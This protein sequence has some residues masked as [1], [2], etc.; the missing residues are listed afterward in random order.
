M[1]ILGQY[2]CGLWDGGG[3]LWVAFFYA[4]GVAFGCWGMWGRADWWKGVLTLASL[5][6]VILA[7]GQIGLS[8]FLIGLTLI[9]PSAVLLIFFLGELLPGWLGFGG[10]PTIVHRPR[11]DAPPKG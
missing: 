10:C 6:M 4:L 8:E 11:K 5:A 1:W 7:C 3:W 2:D 9:A